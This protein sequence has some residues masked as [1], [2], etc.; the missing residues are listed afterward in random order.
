MTIS[1]THL[2][3]IA[4]S[5][6]RRACPFAPCAATTQS[7][8]SVPAHVDED[9]GYRYYT[10]EQAREGEAIRRLREL[11]VPLDE[12]RALLD[13]PPDALREGLAAHRARLEGRTVELRRT[14][15]EL[16]RA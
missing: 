5:P 16:S 2:L 14:L 4:A 9:T 15:E 11:D 13:A 6:G 12:I 1:T 8:C 3:S 7:V 10:L